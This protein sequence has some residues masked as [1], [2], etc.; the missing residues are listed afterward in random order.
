MKSSGYK[1]CFETADLHWHGARPLTHPIIF[2][3]STRKLWSPNWNPGLW[4]QFFFYSREHSLHFKM[5]SNTRCDVN[6]VEVVDPQVNISCSACSADLRLLA[7]WSRGDP[8]LVTLWTI[9]SGKHY[10][11]LKSR[12][13][14]DNLRW[15]LIRNSGCLRNSLE[16][17][18]Q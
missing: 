5:P 4:H 15:T 18:S 1:E 10:Q 6:E 2:P 17:R 13:W 7:S 3:A 14:N 8:E 12:S 16:G 9:S 11:K